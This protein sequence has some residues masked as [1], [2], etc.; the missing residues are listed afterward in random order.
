M[1]ACNAAVPFLA[2]SLRDWADLGT[3]L[4]ECTASG[5]MLAHPADGAVLHVQ[6][7]SVLLHYLG[8]RCLK[9]AKSRLCADDAWEGLEGAP[10]RVLSMCEAFFQLGSISAR[11]SLRLFH[12]GALSALLRLAF[13]GRENPGWAAALGAGTGAGDTAAQLQEALLKSFGIFAEAVPQ[14]SARG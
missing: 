7:P 10:Q 3:L 12:A 14:V 5:Q 6:V 4:H 2:G 13:K 1:E 11:F 8:P 9:G